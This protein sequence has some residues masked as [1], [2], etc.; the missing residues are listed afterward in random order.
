MEGKWAK[1]QAGFRRKHSTMD[2]L[3][4]LRIIAEECCNNK[5]DMFCCFVDFIKAFD[6]MARNNL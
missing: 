3:F 6:T 4:T 1:D 5:S 2:H